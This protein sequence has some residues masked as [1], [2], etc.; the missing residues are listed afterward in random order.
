MK[1]ELSTSQTIVLIEVLRILRDEK[2][3][4]ARKKIY[5]AHIDKKSKIKS[6]NKETRYFIEKLNGDFDEIG[7][8]VEEFGIKDKLFSLYSDTIRRVW[9]AIENDIQ[10]EQD[11]RKKKDPAS[12]QYGYFL[13]WLAS[14]AKK[15]RDK[16]N[17]EEPGF[18]DLRII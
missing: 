13:T 7:F 1:D 15:Y 5:E 6:L 12:T 11:E 18:T 3:I 16:N 9:I 2:N 8:L 10:R 17:L 14:E 4:T